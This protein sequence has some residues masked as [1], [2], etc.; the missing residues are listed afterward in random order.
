MQTQTSYLP[1]EQTLTRYDPQGIYAEKLAIVVQ[2]MRDSAL[3][4]KAVEASM[5]SKPLHECH[6]T[7]DSPCKKDGIC[8]C[9][10]GLQTKL[11]GAMK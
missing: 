4:E 1:A 9:M 7:A 11:S 10:A 3:V 5:V 6:C 2:G 8:R